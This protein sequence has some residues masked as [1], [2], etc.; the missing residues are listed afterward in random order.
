MPPPATVSAAPPAAAGHRLVVI[1]GDPDD[2]GK[3]LDIT[4]LPRVTMGRAGDCN[5]VLA[6]RKVSRCHCIIEN[7]GD[8]NYVIVDNHSSNGTIVNGEKVTKTL[9]GNGDYF[10][11][12]FTVFAYQIVNAPI[13]A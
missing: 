3:E 5:F 2:R 13:E 7:R 4:H 12:G 1:D 10:R 9:L 6:D 8:G 11:L